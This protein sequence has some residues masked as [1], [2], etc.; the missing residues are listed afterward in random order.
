MY[1]GSPENPVDGFWGPL[2]WCCFGQP[3][4][5]PLRLVHYRYLGYAW[6]DIMVQNAEITRNTVTGNFEYAMADNLNLC[7]RLSVVRNQSTGNS[8][9]QLQDILVF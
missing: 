7:S 2:W 5:T 1:P 3:N 9:H 4:R 8:L 6:A